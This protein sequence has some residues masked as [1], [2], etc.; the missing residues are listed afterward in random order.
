M[1]ALGNFRIQFW[2]YFSLYQQFTLYLLILKSVKMLGASFFITL[3]LCE[4]VTVVSCCLSTIPSI[5][6][7]LTMLKFCLVFNNQL[8]LDACIVARFT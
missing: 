7:I 5:L 4:Y 3:F 2:L 1:E 6:I 8:H